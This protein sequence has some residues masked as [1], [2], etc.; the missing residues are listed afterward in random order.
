MRPRPATTRIRVS[1]E[2]IRGPV[3]FDR[4]FFMAP[5]PFFRPYLPMGHTKGLVPYE[6]NAQVTEKSPVGYD[7]PV[8]PRANPYIRWQKVFRITII[9]ST[10]RNRGVQGDGMKVGVLKEIVEDERRVGLVP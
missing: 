8:W 4:Y 6:G 9:L 3:R 1:T 2:I 10:G 7:F 5:S